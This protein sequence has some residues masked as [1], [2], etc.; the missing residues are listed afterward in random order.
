MWRCEDGGREYGPFISDPWGW[1]C[2][3][4]QKSDG[5][6][7]ECALK[8]VVFRARCEPYGGH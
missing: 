7:C 8:E 5:C 6:Y 2:W 3:L 1:G 4:S